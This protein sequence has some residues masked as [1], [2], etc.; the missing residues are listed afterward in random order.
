M[1]RDYPT[2][3]VSALRTVCLVASAGSDAWVGYDEIARRS[4][5]AHTLAVHQIVQLCADGKD[6]KQPALLIKREEQDRRFRSAALSE[7]G[8]SVAAQFVPPGLTV[9]VST[10]IQ[11]CIL[12]ALQIVLS[13][14][15]ALALG[16]LTVLLYIARHQD[17]FG[18]EGAHIREVSNALGISNLTRHLAVL[19]EG[20][21]EQPEHGLVTLIT[22]TKDRR[23]KLP[24]VTVEG[25]A[26]VAKIAA[27]LIK[28]EVIPPRHPSEDQINALPDSRDV[29]TLEWDELL[30]LEG[31]DDIVWVDERDHSAR[32]NA[33]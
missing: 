14:R 7:G 11:D 29:D 20:S 2:L 25:H 27:A 10:Y 3:T 31:W 28:E 23:A 24:E 30:S 16:T 21:S 17:K 26:F 32:P 1:R 5:L 4:G 22:N 8:R 15:P 6:G 12:P 9:D 18:F 33:G 13:Q 19:S